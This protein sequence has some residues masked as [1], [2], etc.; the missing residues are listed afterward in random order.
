MTTPSTRP[1]TTVNTLDFYIYCPQRHKIFHIFLF[2]IRDIICMCVIVFFLFS[3]CA[4]HHHPSLIFSISLFLLK[5]EHQLMTS[6]K[7]FL[8]TLDIF[9]GAFFFRG[10]LVSEEETLG[11]VIFFH[12]ASHKLNNKKLKFLVLLVS[13]EGVEERIW[14]LPRTWGENWTF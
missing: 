8:L 6:K 4:I 3:P 11:N 10:L 2:F 13:R 5:Q 1:K 9:F 12:L 7:K 14:D